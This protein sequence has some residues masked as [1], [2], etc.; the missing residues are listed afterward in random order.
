MH[1]TAREVVIRRLVH[2]DARQEHLYRVGKKMVDADEVA[3]VEM[4]AG[5]VI[6]TWWEVP[7]PACPDCG[8]ALIWA[9]AGLVPGAR[10][11]AGCG[12]LFR[13]ETR[14]PPR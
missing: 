9:E 13:A 4:V 3:D 7:L 8:G 11:C 12:S 1:N 2:Q 10:E 5:P 6:T 14:D